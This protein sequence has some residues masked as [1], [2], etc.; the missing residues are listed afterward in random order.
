MILRRL[1]RLYG[2]WLISV[3]LFRGYRGCSIIGRF[4]GLRSRRRRRGRLIDLYLWVYGFV[5]IFWGVFM[6][7]SWGRVFLGIKLI[8][9]FWYIWKLYY[10]LFFITSFFNSINIISK[11]PSK[12]H[13]QN[14]PTL[15]LTLHKIKTP[16][17]IQ[18]NQQYPNP[19]NPY[20]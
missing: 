7:G 6:G 1:W 10:S 15:Y 3:I 12:T 14:T 9:Y 8:V 2:D 20:T 17:P 11:T 5:V 13:D 4:W 18:P 16:T 19:P